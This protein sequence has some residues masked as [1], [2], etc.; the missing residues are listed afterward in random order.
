VFAAASSVMVVLLL[1]NMNSNY[2]DKR[3]KNEMYRCSEPY[4]TLIVWIVSAS[5]LICIC[6][7]K[8]LINGMNH[9]GI[10]LKKVRKR[11][12]I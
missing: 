3:T 4:A 5:F 12:S 6:F 9:A 1:L 2:F 8:K 10:F 7:N 11:S